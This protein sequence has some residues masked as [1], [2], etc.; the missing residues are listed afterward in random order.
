MIFWPRYIGSWR[1]K[2][3]ALSPLEKGIY[4]E[5]LDYIYANE[6]PLPATSEE[7]CRIAGAKSSAECYA[8]DRVVTKMFKKN[9]VGFTN[10]RAEEEIKKWREISAKRKKAS[11]KR[12]GK[13]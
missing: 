1:A 2:T 9:G 8:V 12:W 7:L 6:G 10:D 5:L 11:D 13:T 4:G 3:S